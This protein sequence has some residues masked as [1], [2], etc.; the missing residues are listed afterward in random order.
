MN[1]YTFNLVTQVDDIPLAGR[2]I[3][4]L[5]PLMTEPLDLLELLTAPQSNASLMECGQVGA[6]WRPAHVCLGPA[7]QAKCNKKL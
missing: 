1:K 5:N 3:N 2:E 4:E 7:L 6:F